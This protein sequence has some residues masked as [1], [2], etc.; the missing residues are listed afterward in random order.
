MNSKRTHALISVD[1]DIADGAGDVAV[2]PVNNVLIVGDVFLRQTEVD[3]VDRTF[4][5]LR[6]PTDDE[7]VRLDV[8]IDEPSGVNERKPVHLNKQPPSYNHA[9][10]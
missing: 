2:G 1:A 8:T 7:V 3:D 9:T 5:H 6:A 4:L 10:S